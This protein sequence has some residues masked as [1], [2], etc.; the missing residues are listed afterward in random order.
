MHYPLFESFSLRNT[1]DMQARLSSLILAAKTAGTE[2]LGGSPPLV[3][4][5]DLASPPSLQPLPLPDLLWYLPSSPVAEPGPQTPT[6]LGVS[7]WISMLDDVKCE[8]DGVRGKG[9]ASSE[10]GEKTKA[11]HGV[12]SGSTGSSS[13]AV[14]QCFSPSYAHHKHTQTTCAACA[15]IWVCL[16]PPSLTSSLEERTHLE[17]CQERQRKSRKALNK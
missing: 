11:R 6:C 13:C 16:L 14:H 10:E 7:V 5:T 2:G 12:K 9:R 15:L 4:N 3:I 17:G 8:Q 1:H